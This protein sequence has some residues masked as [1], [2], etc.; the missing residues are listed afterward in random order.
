MQTLVIEIT[1]GEV[2]ERFR[3]REKLHKLHKWSWVK[4]WMLGPQWFGIRRCRK[5]DTWERVHI[6]VSQGAAS[7]P[8]KDPLGHPQSKDEQEIQGNQNAQTQTNDQGINGI[9][10]GNVSGG[11]RKSIIEQRIT[12]SLTEKLDELIAKNEQIPGDNLQ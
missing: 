7:K 1:S 5:C 9:G 11:T 4:R 12:H 3:L 8:E 6:D 2:K 10:N